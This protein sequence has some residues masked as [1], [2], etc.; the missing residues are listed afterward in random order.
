MQTILDFWF[1]PEMRAQWFMATPDTDRLIR[2]RFEAD[3]L[4][5]AH[6][7]W[8]GSR[9]D[10]DA[11]LRLCILLDQVP[12]NIYRGTARAFAYDRIARR[13]AGDAVDRGI[14]Q[15][16]APDRRLFFYLPFEHSE[17]AADQRRSERLIATLGDAEWLDYAIRH[18][19][20]VERFG[21]FPHRNTVLGRPS[22]VEERVFL[23][24]KQSAF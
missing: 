16:V 20:I 7:S 3:L 13:V 18:R 11:M 1:L 15:Q 9:A 4:V 24:E 5:A 14:D 12:R 21:R 6:G 10:P 2:Q 19:E 22:T 8:E 23:E 17:E